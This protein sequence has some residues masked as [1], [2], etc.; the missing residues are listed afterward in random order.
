MT[1]YYRKPERLHQKWLEQT[2]EFCKV[3]GYKTD[4]N[5]LL[6]YMLIMKHISF[7]FKKK[8]KEN[9]PIYSGTK[10]NKLPRIKA[11]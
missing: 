6:S 9:N 5:L 11:D 7:I 4:R 8:N 10:K 3:P 2:H 1:Q